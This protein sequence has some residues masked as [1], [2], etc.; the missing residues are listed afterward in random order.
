MFGGI[1]SLLTG[2]LLDLSYMLSQNFQLIDCRLLAARYGGPDEGVYQAHPNHMVV[3]KPRNVDDEDVL[4]PSLPMSE[5]TYMSYFLQRIR[6]AEISRNIVDQNP[7]TAA[8]SSRPSS[9]THIMAMDC[10]L[11]Q[12]IE[13]IPVYFQLRDYEQNSSSTNSSNIFIQSYILNTLIHT[14]RCKLHLAFLTSG[15]RSSPAYAFSREACLRSARIIVRAEVSLL[16]S[17]HPFV[18]IRFRLPTIL[19]SVFMAT[20]VL[21]MDA[22]VN[23]P[24]SIQDEM[25]CGELADGLRIIEDAKDHSLAAANLHESLMQV[26]AKC[27]VRQHEQQPV[28][29]M[30]VPRET[31]DYRLDAYDIPDGLLVDVGQQRIEETM[32]IDAIQWDEL[33]AGV[34]SSSFF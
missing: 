31:L 2:T 34:A 4:Q 28:R 30:A 26:F 20:I 18:R 32:P 11:E 10:E 21:S 5:P 1:W 17:Q 16:R 27:R 33:F 24:G 29:N 15:P 23:R 22:C 19:H 12:M 8:K 14:Q 13:E 3:N 9:Y 25:A 7:I 6:L